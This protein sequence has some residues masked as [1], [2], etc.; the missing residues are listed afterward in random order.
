MTFLGP[1]DIGILPLP[2]ASKSIG[3][4]HQDSRHEDPDDST[5][6]NILLLSWL[7]TL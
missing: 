3:L 6:F 7:A 1:I 5:F 2:A 4:G